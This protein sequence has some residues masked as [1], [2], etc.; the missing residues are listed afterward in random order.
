MV[1]WAVA[2]SPSP[3]Q[4]SPAEC[5]GRGKHKNAVY[6]ANTAQ[7]IPVG[8][9]KETGMNYTCCFYF[10]LWFDWNYSIR[11][12]LI[13][14]VTI[15]RYFRSISEQNPIFHICCSGLVWNKIKKQPNCEDFTGNINANYLIN[16]LHLQQMRCLN[17]LIFSVQFIFY[18]IF[19]SKITQSHN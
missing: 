14:A 7:L 16:V 12:H 6:N 5:E 8:R 2:R 1:I 13:V 9:M 19:A 3:H 17:K 4:G 18:L 11:Q 15:F 10:K